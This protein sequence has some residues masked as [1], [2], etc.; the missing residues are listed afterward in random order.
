MK[1]PSCGTENGDDSWNC[2]TCRINLYWAS[3]H[4]DEL[5]EI[6]NSS[7]RANRV[8]SPSFLV[9]AHRDA[10]NDRAARGHDVDNKVRVAARKAMRRSSPPASAA[11]DLGRS[12]REDD[13]DESRRAV[14]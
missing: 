9:D 3:Q 14:D 10:M 12:L 13:R 6:R 8:S 11:P 2:V 7:G 4:Y 5:A 1:C